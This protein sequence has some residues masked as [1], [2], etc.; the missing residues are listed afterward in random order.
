MKKHK[1]ILIILLLASVFMGILLWREQD[2]TGGGVLGPPTN[3]GVGPLQVR[4]DFIGNHTYDQ[5]LYKAM[6]RDIGASQMANV[7]SEEEMN[8]LLA[9]LENKATSAMVL[10]FDKW[11]ADDCGDISPEVNRLIALMKTQDAFFAS[12]DVKKRV[13]IYS[14]FRSFVA[15]QG[16]VNS[17]ITREYNQTDTD[18]LQARISSALSQEGVNSC[19]SMSDK[20]RKWLAT[21]AEFK[22]IV[23]A[24]QQLINE[25]GSYEEET[26]ERYKPYTFYYKIFKTSGKC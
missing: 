13:K 17:L 25:P 9:S 3:E 22:K 26:C 23:D 19:H 6:K 20:S 1:N 18:A 15:I 14:N 7:I 12:P 11:M 5:S 4:L 21:I 24:Y 8:I 2:T 10:S 16:R